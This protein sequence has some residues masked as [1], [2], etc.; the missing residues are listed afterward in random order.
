MFPLLV[1]SI[2]VNDVLFS[3]CGSPRPF[4]GVCGLLLRAFPFGDDFLER[5]GFGVDRPERFGVLLRGVRRPVVPG[6]SNKTK[7]K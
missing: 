3:G 7:Q 5:D 4:R 2:R 6:K 1:D